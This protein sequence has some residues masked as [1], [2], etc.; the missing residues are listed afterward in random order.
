MN[1]RQKIIHQSNYWY[2]DGLKR[3]QIHDLS[4]AIISLRR[5]I[6]YNI[7]N[8]EARNLLGLV[9]YGRGEVPDALVQ[10]IISKNLKVRDNVANYF[11]RCV[12][13]TPGELDKISAAIK[14]YNQCIVYCQQNGEDLALIQLKKI[15]AAHPTFVK[16]YQLMALLL[17]QKEQY[18]RA[19]QVLKKAQMLDTTDPITLNYIYEMSL[20]KGKHSKED[21]GETVTYTVGNETIIQPATVAVKEPAGMSTVVNIILGI[22]VGAALVW[23]LFVPTA[24]S[25]KSMKNAKAITAYSEQVASQKAE[26][27]ALKKELETF[28]ATSSE[29]ETTAANAASTSDSYEALFKAQSQLDSSSYSNATMAETLK[30]ANRDSL[31]EQG[32]QIYDKLATEIFTP[33]CKKSYSSGKEKLE[34]KDYD[35]A[36]T[37]LASV[38]EMIEG[39]DDWNAMLHLAEAYAGKGDTDNATKYY[40]RVVEA[41]AGTDAAGTA[42]EALKQTGDAAPADSGQDGSDSDNASG[43]EE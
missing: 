8:V 7:Q 22:A 3:A 23:F 42:Q 38:V 20:L 11:I 35:G 17:I 16:A 13:E 32:Q 14:K 5:S 10:W 19:R 36:I 21:K 26:I 27:N 9:Y 40:Q 43:T 28:R 37:D 12:Q 6:Q 15:V 1:Y 39:Y 24:T 2:N 29:A 33:V 34:A 30:T 18:N 4:G 41:G 31:G 25:N